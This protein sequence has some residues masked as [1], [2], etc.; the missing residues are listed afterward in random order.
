MKMGE[1]KF[2]LKFGKKEHNDVFASG[3]LFCSNA[4]TFWGIEE[5]FKFKG[6]G[7]RLEGSSKVFAQKIAIHDYSDHSLITQLGMSNGLLRYAPAKNIPVF[8]LFAAHEKDC[9]VDENGNFRIKLSD[10]TK[11]IIKEHFPNADSV[12][13][14]RDPK[15][16]L[17]DVEKSIGCEIKHE[18]VHYFRIDEGLP[19]N[20]GRRAMEH[21]YMMY[22]TQDVPPVVEG[23]SRKYF[24]KA[25]YAYRALLC[26]DVFFQ[27]EQEYR[28][29]LPKELVSKEGRL[30]PVKN[31]Q[32]IKVFDLEEFFEQ[33]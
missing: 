7:D 30:Y 31:S 6:Q 17:T 9:V 29:V 28:I 20:D 14:I 27:G 23:G 12:A 24:F 18:L 10:E 19:T 21:E 11:R 13:V 22:L 33:F 3:N 4:K 1:I 8:C 25:E 15:Q 2:F 26:K 16:F 32:E 5:K